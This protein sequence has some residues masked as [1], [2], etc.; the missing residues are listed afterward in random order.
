MER[1]ILRAL[2][3]CAR[4]GITTVHDAGVGAREIEAYRSLIR[5]GQMPIRAYVMIGGTGGLL[6]SWLAKGPAIDDYMTVRSIKLVADGALGSRG[7]AML[8]PYSDD[9]GNRGLSI[10]NRAAIREVR[11]ATAAPFGDQSFAPT[12]KP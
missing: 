8:E 6:D 11:A 9:P 1:R 2:Q 7:A 10:L 3:E 4:L 5:K 12:K